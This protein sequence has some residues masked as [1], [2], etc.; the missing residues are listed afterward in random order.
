MVRQG[1]GFANASF[2]ENVL[3]PR[4]FN[5]ALYY[6]TQS[7][8]SWAKTFKAVKH[9]NTP[10]TDIDV[11]ELS[12]ET[13][14]T[15]HGVGLKKLDRNATLY[16]EKAATDFLNE[17]LLR[18]DP[19]IHVLSVVITGQR[20]VSS[21]ASTPA[22]ARHGISFSSSV[23]SSIEIET[24]VTGVYLPPPEVTFEEVVEESI[25]DQPEVFVHRLKNSELFVDI[26][27]VNAVS[28]IRYFPTSSPTIS[29]DPHGKCGKSMCTSM[30]RFYVLVSVIMGGVFIIWALHVSLSRVSIRRRGSI[31]IENDENCKQQSL[32][33]GKQMDED[34][35]YIQVTSVE[36]TVEYLD[37]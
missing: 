32:N 29:F 34:I 15:L 21:Q 11:V 20:V 2:S 4:I 1:I 12:S 10:D 27:S 7:S 13:K 18:S 26:S 6:S 22:R 24:A 5:G 3:Q 19:P 28:F 37:E 16:F 9:A 14:I 35:N 23:T 33:C 17:K 8:S 36:E 25:N 30:L 31:I